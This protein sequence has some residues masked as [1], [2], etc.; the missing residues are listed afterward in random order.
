MAFPNIGLAAKHLQ[1]CSPFGER[2]CSQAWSQDNLGKS[3]FRTLPSIIIVVKMKVILFNK[4]ITII[5]L[6]LS[7]LITEID[8][9]RVN[10]FSFFN[11]F[12]KSLQISHQHFSKIT[13]LSFL[14]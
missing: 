7:L 14:Y 12:D 13:Q 8:K 1:H 5:P 2:A 4:T 3:N 11:T 9:A 10:L 6:I